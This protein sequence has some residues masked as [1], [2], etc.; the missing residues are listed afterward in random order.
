VDNGD[1]G[2]GGGGDDDGDVVLRSARNIVVLCVRAGTNDGR[3]KTL[4]HTHTYTPEHANETIAES[5][6]LDGINRMS[7]ERQKL[8]KI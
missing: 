8:L 1:G 2:G 3:L 6:A 7:G 5:A 4:V